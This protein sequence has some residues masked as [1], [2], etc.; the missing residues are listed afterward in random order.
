MLEVKMT[1]ALAA[2][3]A[4]VWKTIRDFNGLPNFVAAVAQSTMKG[5]GVGAL[6]TLTLQDGGII[7]EKLESFDDANRTLSYSIVESPLPVDEYLST[8]V[9]KETG[10]GRCELLWSSTFKAKGAADDEAKEVIQGI[11]NMGFEGLAKLHS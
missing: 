9:V 4:D 3:A 11:Y 5:E 1:K 8:M 6:R 10:P 7:V 2:P